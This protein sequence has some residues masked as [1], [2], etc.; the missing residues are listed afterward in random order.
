M[1]YLLLFSCLAIQCHVLHFHVLQFGPSFSCPAFS[2][3]AFSA[4]PLYSNHVEP[5]SQLRLYGKDDRS[6]E[7][8]LHR[9]KSRSRSTDFRVRFAPFSTPAPLTRSV[10]CILM[11]I[12]HMLTAIITNNAV[13]LQA[14]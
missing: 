14:A 8:P 12:V 2:H 1:N 7:V 6:V 9:I 10:Q 11:L 3:L 4:T 13:G 5:G